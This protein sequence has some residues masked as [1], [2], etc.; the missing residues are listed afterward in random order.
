VVAA[1]SIDQLS[2]HFDLRERGVSVAERC[3]RYL[4]P[5]YS[6]L[7]AVRE[8]SLDVRQGERVA[9]IG[10][11]GAGKS[12]TIK[13]LT[14]IFHPSSGAVRV[15]GFD[16]VEQR[17]QVA[18]RIGTVFGQRSQL[19]Y[20]L[21]P[22]ASFRVIA[23]IYN[24]PNKSYQATL[25]QLIAEFDIER[26]ANRPVRELSLG[27]R[28]RC[29]LI[30]NLL[31]KPDV[32]FLDEPTIGLDLVSKDAIRQVIRRRSEQHGSTVFLT[33]HDIA[34]IETVC[35]RVI[36]IDKG[37]IV[38]DASLQELRKRYLSNRIVKLHARPHIE[39]K[40]MRGIALQSEQNGHYQFSIDLS[41]T[42][43]SAAVQ[44]ILNQA[45]VSDLLVETPPLEQ[46][47]R[48]IYLQGSGS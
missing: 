18:Q 5:R 29:E 46:V 8:I 17:Q 47:I 32:L 48:Q 30:A 20:H 39:W 42:S 3:R 40:L 10:P 14:G 24:I 28:M 38:M 2:K 21:P 19:W 22:L 4:F 27:E 23:E 43:C 31:H 6:E 34:D 37:Q 13:M 7:P 33:S 15:L 16:P 36:I 1:I 25:E 35:D 11:N 12:T 45:D 44:A 9:F 41:A 26:F